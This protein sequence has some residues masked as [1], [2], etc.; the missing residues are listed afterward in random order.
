MSSGWR[1]SDRL[2]Q[3]DADY[4]VVERSFTPIRLLTSGESRTESFATQAILDDIISILGQITGTRDR[5]DAT[6]AHRVVH[7]RALC[8][9]C[10]DVQGTD[11]RGPVD[12]LEGG[13]TG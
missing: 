8:R 5:L 4:S 1:S 10:A 6:T 7:C 2:L 3:I 12:L 13:T 11:G 9:Q